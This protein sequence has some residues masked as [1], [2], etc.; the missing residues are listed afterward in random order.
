MSALGQKQTMTPVGVMSALPP[1]ADIETRPR[2]RVAF[3]ALRRFGV[4]RLRPCS[5]PLHQ[6]GVSLLSPRSGQGIVAGQI[7]RLE[8]VRRGLQATNLVRMENVRR[9]LL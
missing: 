5:L 4:D 6:N 2:L 7:N 8:V 9:K 1:K 3:G